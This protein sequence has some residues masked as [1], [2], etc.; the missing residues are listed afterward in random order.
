MAVCKSCSQRIVWVRTEAKEGKPS[1]SMPLDATED[2]R[3]LAVAAGN[4]VVTAT[5]PNGD[6]TVRYVG[7]GEGTYVSH[8]VSCRFAKD[9]RKAKGAAR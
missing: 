3:P 9:H 6:M 2:G 8:F 7:R 1:K 4:I 5:A